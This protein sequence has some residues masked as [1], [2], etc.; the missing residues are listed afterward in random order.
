[1]TDTT[2]RRIITMFGEMLLDVDADGKAVPCE[3]VTAQKLAEA[4]VILYEENTRLREQNAKDVKM[5]F[6]MM[7]TR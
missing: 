6:G 3:G 2:Y 5:L 4:V 7:G 1:M